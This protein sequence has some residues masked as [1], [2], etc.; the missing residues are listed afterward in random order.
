MLWFCLLVVMYD[1]IGH[2]YRAK[3]GFQSRVNGSSTT[4][5]LKKCKNAPQPRCQEA[6]PSLRSSFLNKIGN[7]A[8]AR[9]LVNANFRSRYRDISP[10]NTT[11]ASPSRVIIPTNLAYCLFENQLKN[12]KKGYGT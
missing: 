6:K 7:S 4:N 8:L 10:K 1:C 9:W 11:S 2:R 3:Y 12:C 5:S